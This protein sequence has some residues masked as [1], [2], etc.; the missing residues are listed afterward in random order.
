VEILGNESEAKY[1][2]FREAVTSNELPTLLRSDYK[3]IL[4]SAYDGV[5]KPLLGLA[6]QVNSDNESETYRGLKPI[7]DLD[8][9]V[10]Q[11]QE[12]PELMLGE[13]TTVTITNRKYGGLIAVTDEMLRY[14]K[15]AEM[16]RL[17]AMLGDA[18]GRQ[19]EKKIA[20]AIETSG[21]YTAYGS[22]VTLTRANLEAVV[23]MY[24][25]QTQT[26]ADG[27]TI[28]GGYIPDTLLIPPDLEY[29]ARRIINSTLIPGSADNDMN[30]LKSSL[31][32]VVSHYL[33]STT[34][35]YVMKSSWAN[36][37]LFQKVIFPPELSLQNVTGENLPDSSFR[38]DKITYK[39]RMLFGVGVLDAKAIVRSTT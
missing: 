16:N 4:L 19:V 24:K 11:G 31:N 28:K 38:Y 6:Y 26:A 22:T 27:T 12:Y 7:Q 34:I 21:N 5:E 25:K 20:A 29:D 39:A 17:G 36:G 32:I 15:L 35:F 33:T 30:V 9:I 3:D 23:T 18:L 14:N 37:L 1:S 8:D 10:P 2:R 13:K